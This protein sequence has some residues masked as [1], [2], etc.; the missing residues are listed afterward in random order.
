[1]GW[2]NGRAAE[3]NIS[4]VYGQ[5]FQVALA[6][7][8]RLIHHMASQHD[9]LGKESHEDLYQLGIQ[10]LWATVVSCVCEHPARIHMEGGC[11]QETRRTEPPVFPVFC[12]CTKL[13]H[14][15]PLSTTFEKWFKTRLGHRLLDQVSLWKPRRA[16]K[17][18]SHTMPF[19]CLVRR[20]RRAVDTIPLDD[21]SSVMNV[22]WN[23]EWKEELLCLNY[24]E[25]IDFEIAEQPAGRVGIRWI[26]EGPEVGAQYLVEGVQVTEETRGFRDSEIPGWKCTMSC[27][28]SL[29]FPRLAGPSTLVPTTLPRK[30]DSLLERIATFMSTLW[31][32]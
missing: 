32:A 14:L 21:V 7:Y 12:R 18:V 15:D 25:G 26:R 24:Y 1:M 10:E 13:R 11:V 20:S 30:S 8:E 3:V 4:D 29:E 19:S 2:F 16:D 6:R 5:R 27:G 23:T 17:K 28:N 22:Q 9:V 31:S